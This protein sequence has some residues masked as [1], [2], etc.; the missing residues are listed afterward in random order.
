MQ[1][2]NDL[3]YFAEVVDGGSFAAAGRSLGIPKS[4]LSRR[5]AELE[6]RLG[7]RLLQRTTRKLS[8]TQAGETYHR[9][10]VAMREQAEAAD[11]AVALVQTE[12]RGTVRVTCP[13]TLA[14]STIGPLLPRFLLTHPQVRIEMQVTNR[15]VDLVQEGVDVALR[16]RSSL[17]DSGTLVVKRLGPTLG[18]LL[19]S[20][21]L[22]QRLGQPRAPDDLKNLPTVAMSAIDGR[23][24]W[25]L[26]GPNGQAFELQHQ[27]L[28]IAD[29]LLTLKFAVLQGTG[30]CVLPDY[31]CSQELQRGELVPVLPGWAPPA[32]AVLAVFPTRRGMVPAVRR[33]LDFL[34]ANMAGERIV[35]APAQIAG[36]AA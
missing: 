21:Q 22:L 9:H 2:L 36:Q 6:A 13:V 16:V 11:E 24:S 7:V 29:D 33:F 31:M 10:C 14:Q 12:P 30:I 18:A 4:R 28:C 1:D 8:L 32:A 25:R 26:L 23:A 34:G 5:V 20:P 19:A 27:P 15:V 3:L 17:D 35:A